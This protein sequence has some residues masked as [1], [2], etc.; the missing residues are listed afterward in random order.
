VAD[1]KTMNRSRNQLATSYAPESFFTFEGGIGGC[2]SRSTAGDPA[3]L[4]E[5]TITQILERLKEFGTAWFDAAMHARDSEPGKPPI[6]P[7]QCVDVN[8]LDEAR[9]SFETPAQDRLYLSK[10]SHMEYTPAPLTFVCRTCGLFRDYENLERF[11]RAMPS[12][13]ANTCPHPR[14]Q[15]GRCSW[16]QLDVIFVH[17]SGNWSAAAPGQWVWKGGKAILSRA[18]CVACGSYDFTLNKRSPQIG[19]WFFVCAK[20]ETPTQDRWLLNDAD[21]LNIFRVPVGQEGRL[22][23]PTEVRME[24]IPYRASSAY[25]VQSELFIDFKEGGG[26]LLSRLRYG[27]QEQLED[28]V[29]GAYG[30]ES[31]PITDADVEAACSK[32]ADCT[33][34]LKIYRDAVKGIANFTDVL[35]NVDPSLRNVLELALTSAR[36]ARDQVLRALRARQILLP[37]ISLPQSVTFAMETRRDRFAA[38]FDPFRLAIE[39]ATLK[40]TRLDVDRVTTGKRPYVSFA[41]LDADLSAETAEETKQ[42]EMDAVERLTQMGIADMGLIREFELCK[43]S[44]GYTRMEAGPV[45]R[46]KREMD[47]PVRLRL[48]PTVVY[49]GQRKHPI[50]VVQQANQAIYV[51]LDQTKVI[52]WLQ[53]LGCDDMFVLTDDQKLGA[54]LLSVTQPMDRFL[55]GLPEGTSPGTYFYLYTLLHSF[56]HLLMKHISEYSGL[57]LGS[58]GE[59]IFPADAAFVVYRSGTTMDLGNLSAMWRNAGVAMLSSILAPKA[60]QCGTGSLCTQRGG[61]CPDCLMVPET[62]CIASNKLLSR[63]VLRSIGGA[64]RFDKRGDPIRGYLEIAD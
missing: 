12:M 8:L 50:Y 4:S 38:R 29:A 64:P 48:F 17:W 9:A 23:G 44:F 57:D 16:E 37:G 62:S 19:H 42:L 54:G 21:S 11:A 34:E 6:L 47:M 35:L 53:T 58:L 24:A 33:E 46:N 32:G 28:F 20:C 30:F 18:A 60:T 5:A 51:R 7:E 10:P 56:S 22:K 36:N 15:R 55:D 43:F 59:Y 14:P 31:K 61:S 3:E 45:L 26:A 27:N 13:T 25:Y 2:I 40:E 49:S 41:H 52:R 39:H 1:S 63:S